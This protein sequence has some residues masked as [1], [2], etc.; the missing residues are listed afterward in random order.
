[1]IR[2][3]AKPCDAERCR[4]IEERGVK[5]EHGEFGGPSSWQLK[6]GYAGIQ[7]S[8]DNLTPMGPPG[9]GAVAPEI[10]VRSQRESGGEPRDVMARGSSCHWFNLAGRMKLPFSLPGARPDLEGNI[11]V[12]PQDG[13]DL[14]EIP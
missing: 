7:S 4:K 11:L 12:G 9:D 5:R 10:G 6:A 13:L 3:A 8:A 14:P 1:Q 2:P